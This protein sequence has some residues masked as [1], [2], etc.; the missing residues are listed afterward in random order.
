MHEL[1]PAQSDTEDP[2]LIDTNRRLIKPIEREVS[3]IRKAEVEYYDEE[4][5]GY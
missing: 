1:Q 4:S 2:D 5:D 3:A